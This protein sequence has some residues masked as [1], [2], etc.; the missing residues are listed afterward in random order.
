VA[1]AVT[2]AQAAE[3]LQVKVLTVVRAAIKAA[4]LAVEQG[5]KVAM[6]TKMEVAHIAVQEV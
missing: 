5:A 4:R 1:Q 2:V 6:A 3:V